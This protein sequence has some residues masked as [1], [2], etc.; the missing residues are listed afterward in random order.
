MCI[1]EQIHNAIKESLPPVKQ[2][3]ELLSNDKGI[4]LNYGICVN[5]VKSNPKYS[6]KRVYRMK[7]EAIKNQFIDCFLSKQIKRVQ[8]IMKI[9]NDAIKNHF[10]K[11]NSY[12]YIMEELDKLIVKPKHKCNCKNVGFGFC[13]CIDDNGNYII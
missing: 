4:M 3:S 1:Q 6:N 10:E 12:E 8:I 13:F 11:V 5:A 2:V 7:I 9:K